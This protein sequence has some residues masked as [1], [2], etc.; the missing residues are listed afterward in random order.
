M[1][2]LSPALLCVLWGRFAHPPISPVRVLGS[3][4]R[5]EKISA[6]DVDAICQ[7]AG[8]QAVRR[9]RYIILPKDFEEGWKEHVKKK[10]RDYDFYSL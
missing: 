3:V 4:C 1:G 8:M 5:P 7:E 6:A 9:N 10:D 2:D